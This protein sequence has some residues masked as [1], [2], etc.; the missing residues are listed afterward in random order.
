[1]IERQFGRSDDEGNVVRILER[2]YQT[3]VGVFRRD[4]RAGYLIPDEKKFHTEIYIPLSACSNIKNNVKAVAKIT[5]YPYGK[6]PGGEII[7]VL[8]DDDD[9]FS[10]ELSIIRSYDLREEFPPQVEK[11]AKKQSARGITEN[12]TVNR[13][14][15]RDKLIVTI[16][17]ADT[18]DLYKLSCTFHYLRFI[19]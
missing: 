10:E 8:G 1:M 12:D 14:D 17:G 13:R 5:S 3:I 11:E 16:D 18:R 6:A 15:F 7:E 9:F 19:S 2:G 4:R